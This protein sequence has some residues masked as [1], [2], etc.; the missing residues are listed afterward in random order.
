[1]V[2]TLPAVTFILASDGKAILVFDVGGS[3]ITGG[4]FNFRSGTVESSNR[5]IV[6]AG[7]SS[8]QFFSVFGSL[9]ASLLPPATP[10]S[11]IAV[12]IPSPFDH[13]GGVS[14]MQHKYRQLYGLDLKHALSERLVCDPTRIH[15]L[16][17]AAAFLMGELDQGAAAGSRRS[18]GIT[19]GTGVGSAFA[20]NL[21]VVT[22]RPEVP[23]GGEIWNLPYRDGIVED[24]ISAATI[25]REYAGLTGVSA[26]VREIADRTRDQPEARQVFA[27]FGRELGQ[28]LRHTCN[29]FAPERIVLGGGISRCAAAFLGAVEPELADLAVR[30][31]ISSLFERA[32]LIGAGISWQ[33]KF[34]PESMFPNHQPSNLAE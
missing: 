16:N 15:F 13:D 7:I 22:S 17:D 26:E 12:A 1:M 14:Y 32:P 18:V 24:V 20:V 27:H 10:L 23:A 19:L 3:H 11:G 28:V 30:V 9:V 2:V 5:L 29:T 21:E 25:Q 33:R 4:L 6:P 8:D 31:C 34:S